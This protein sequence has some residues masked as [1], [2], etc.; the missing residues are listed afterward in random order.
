M[1]HRTPNPSAPMLLV[2]INFV[3]LVALLSQKK[4]KKQ[5]LM[6][7]LIFGGIKAA[8]IIGLGLMASVTMGAPEVVALVVFSALIRGTISFLSAWALLALLK[9]IDDI[10]IAAR[11][12]PQG[13]ITKPKSVVLEW[14]GVLVAGFICAFS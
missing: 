13:V 3:L 4:S 9:R 12:A 6:V 7:G 10:E 1:V 11:L 2:A 8:V 14:T 5:P